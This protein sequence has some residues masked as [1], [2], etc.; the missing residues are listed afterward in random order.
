MNPFQELKG[1][2]QMRYNMGQSRT[3]IVVTTINWLRVC[4]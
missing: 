3:Q 2:E 4:Y 1:E